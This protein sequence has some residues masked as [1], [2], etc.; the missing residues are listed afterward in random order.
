MCLFCILHLIKELLGLW[1]IL[2]DTKIFRSA[3]NESDWIRAL[4]KISVD[5]RVYYFTKTMLKI[6]HNFIFHERIVSDDIDPPRIQ[7]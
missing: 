5:E 2:K 1:K 7:Y 6:T 3:I 4:S